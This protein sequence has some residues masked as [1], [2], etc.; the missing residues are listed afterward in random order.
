[1]IKILLNKQ[2]QNLFILLAVWKE[3]PRKNNPYI[4]VIEFLAMVCA[5]LL[6]NLLTLIF[7][8]YCET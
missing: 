7:F 5:Y 6:I 1:M 4:N 8:K 2:L 3:L